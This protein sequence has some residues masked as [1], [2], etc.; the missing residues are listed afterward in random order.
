MY[1]SIIINLVPICVDSPLIKVGFCVFV[2]KTTSFSITNIHDFCKDKD[3]EAGAL[4]LE[5]QPTKICITQIYRSHSG[6]LQYFL[7][8][9]ESI[10]MKLYKLDLHFIICGDINI[11]YFTETHKREQLNNMLISF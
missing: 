5:F 4:R 3:L 11:N 7:N 6:N 8:G 9:L 10:I 1:L 2:H